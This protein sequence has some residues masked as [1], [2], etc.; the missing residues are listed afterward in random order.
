MN[1]QESKLSCWPLRLFDS[2]HQTWFCSSNK[3]WF[4]LDTRA[5]LMWLTPGP[6]EQRADEGWEPSCCVLSPPGLLSAG[7][8][9]KTSI[10]HHFAW[11]Y[12]QCLLLILHM[13]YRKKG[14]WKATLPSSDPQ[15]GGPSSLCPACAHS[16]FNSLLS[17]LQLCWI[18]RCGWFLGQQVGHE[19]I[20]NSILKRMW[21]WFFMCIN[22]FLTEC[23]S[24][25]VGTSKHLLAKTLENSSS[26]IYFK[27]DSWLPLLIWPWEYVAYMIM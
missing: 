17:L 22:N 15:G 7:M 26:Y 5:S 9:M 2:F 6:G 19:R 27:L 24:Y 16:S 25:T 12:C 1:Q 11:W 20:G 14:A 4:S 3:M 8:W 21:T 23:H 13:G 10:N 18:A